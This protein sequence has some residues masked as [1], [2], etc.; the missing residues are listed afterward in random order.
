[1]SHFTV[2][3]PAGTEYSF[4]TAEEFTQAIKSGGITADWEIFH[5]TGKRWLPITRH[6]VFMGGVIRRS[7]AGEERK[8]G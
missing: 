3:N 5:S 6:P 2:R 7:T 4:G 8:S 1:V